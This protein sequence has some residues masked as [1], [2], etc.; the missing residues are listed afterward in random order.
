MKRRTA[1][2][3][4]EKVTRGASFSEML[5][6]MSGVTITSQ[7]DRLSDTGTVPLP[8]IATLATKGAIWF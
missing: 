5:Q 8:H 3:F 7:G 2:K 6:I 1:K 4:L